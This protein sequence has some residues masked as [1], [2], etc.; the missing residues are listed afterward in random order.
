MQK[1]I[2]CSTPSIKVIDR[3]SRSRREGFEIISLGFFPVRNRIGDLDSTIDLPAIVVVGE[4]S[5]GR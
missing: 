2:R 5:S 1:S 4:Q 3:L